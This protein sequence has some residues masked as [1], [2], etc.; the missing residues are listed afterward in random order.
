V[1]FAVARHEGLTEELAAE[2][3]DQWEHS[4]LSER[5][6]AALVLA[7]AFLAVDGPPSAADQATLHEHFSD[8]ELVELGIGLALF[9]GFSKM[10]IALGLEP[11]QM[12]TT[13]VA[14]PG[15]SRPAD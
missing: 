7:D 2:V 12:Q 11:E 13:V 10:L 14:T 9:H 3:D 1:R 15:S 4:T 5:H 8:A 6:K